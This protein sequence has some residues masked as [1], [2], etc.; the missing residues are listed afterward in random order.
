MILLSSQVYAAWCVCGTMLV[1][2]KQSTYFPHNDTYFFSGRYLKTYYNCSKHVRD[3]LMIAI[4][5]DRTL[6]SG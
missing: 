6:R 1:G 4:K 2:H 5:Q 3:C